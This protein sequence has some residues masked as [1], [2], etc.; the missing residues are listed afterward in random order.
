MSSKETGWKP[1]LAVGIVLA[2]AL[3]TGAAVWLGGRDEDAA[4][5]PGLTLARVVGE[6]ERF[7]G[8]TVTVSGR[9]RDALPPSADS[10]YAVVLAGP[11]GE[12]LLVVPQQ[13][14]TLP[15]DLQPGTMLRVRGP[16][17]IVGGDEASPEREVLPEGG[18]IDA[19]RGRAAIYATTVEEIDR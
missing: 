3:V 4:A 9:V 16:V 13:A 2:A 15:D 8:Q 18:V 17:R 7:V 12:R 5:Q 19:F 11:G 10:D 1:W 6:P 14:G